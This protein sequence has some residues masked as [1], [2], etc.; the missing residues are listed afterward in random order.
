MGRTTMKSKAIFVALLALA[1]G[2]QA[3]PVI[4]SEAAQ[5]AK[6]W[7][8]SGLVV[9]AT[10]E[11]VTSHATAQGAGF[12]AV[13]LS[14]GGTVFLSGD[15]TRR[16]VIAL[17]PAGAETIDPKSPLWAL[18]SRDQDVQAAVVSANAAGGAGTSASADKS[19]AEREW[20]ELLAE[21]ADRGTVV[22]PAKAV[23]A[24]T[25]HVSSLSDVRV[26]P[27]VK[28]KWAQSTAY[29]KRCYNYYTPQ[30]S[31]KSYAVCGCVATAMSQLMRY[32]RYPTG[33]VT[34]VTRTC[35][36]EPSTKSKAVATKELTTQ[37]GVYDWS[38]MP[39]VPEDGVTDEQCQAIG[40]L[41]SDAGISVCMNYDTLKAG[42][43]GAFMFNVVRALKE[44]FGYASA[45]YYRAES[46]VTKSSGVVRNAMLS[47]FDAGYPVLMGVSGD[48]GHAIVGDGY[49]YKGDTLYVH[50]NMGWAGQDNVWYNL[51]DIDCA[52]SGYH[53]TTFEDV[54][55]NVFPKTGGTA[56][57]SG[58]V[59]DDEGTGVES[60]R[61]EICRSGETDPVVVDLTTNGVYGARLAPGTYDVTAFTAGGK[62]S[63][64]QKGVLVKAPTV[65]TTS[66]TGVIYGS[67]T[68]TY[69][70]VPIATAVGN[71]QNSK[72]IV[73]YQPTVQ[74]GTTQYATLDKALAAAAAVYEADPDKKPVTIE[75]IDA[76][77]LEKPFT[78][79]FPCVLTSADP[80]TL[81]VTRAAGAVL[82]VAAGGKVEVVN[83]TV[84]GAASEKVFNV[85]TGGSVTIGA[86]VNLG[87]S[88]TVP[89]IVTAQADGF[90]FAGAP[91]V[92]FAVDC[93]AARG[94]DAVFGYAT[95]DFATAAAWAPKFVNLNDPNGEIAGVAEDGGSAP[96][97]LKWDV[98][99][100]PLE[101][102]VAY[103][104]L[105][106]TVKT[107]CFRR[108]DRLFELF[109][110][111]D[112]PGEVTI[113]ADC[114]MTR[115]V[116]VTHDLTIRSENGAVVSGPSSSSSGG[117][118]VPSGVTLVVDGLSFDGLSCNSLFVVNGGVL[119]LKGDMAI[120]NF[121][122]TGSPTAAA[123]CA[124]NGARVVVGSD[125]GR[126]VFES[127]VNDASD[128]STGGAMYAY[129]SDANRETEI[130]LAGDV[131]ITGCR[132][133]GAGGGIY[134]GKAAALSLSG[135]LT[136]KDNV[137]G[138]G[139]STASDVYCTSKA[140]GA[141]VVG[142]VKTGSCV[143]IR[144]Q[145]GSNVGAAFAAVDGLTEAEVADSAAAFF[146]DGKDGLVAAP[147]DDD[148]SLVWTEKP[149]GIKPVSPDVAHVH[150]TGASGSDDYYASIEDALAVLA[151]ADGTIEIMRDTTI[152]SN[153]VI[154]ANVTL[155]GDENGPYVITRAGPYEFQV[156]DGATLT[157]ENL[158]FS[159]EGAAEHLFYVDGGEFVL[160]DGATIEKVNGDATHNGGAVRIIA[161]G[162]FV[163]KKGSRIADCKNPYV[164]DYLLNG[165]GGA[166]LA[167]RDSFV[168]LEGGVIESCEADLG[169]GIFI[170]NQSTV[171][172]GGD[173]TV[174]ANGDAS[175]APGN[176]YVPI[177]SDLLLIAPL[178]TGAIGVTQDEAA[179]P[180]VFGHVSDEFTGTDAQLADSAHRFGN[181]RNGDVGI[182]VRNGSE[183]LLVW[184]DGLDANGNYVADGKTYV[185]VSGGETLTAEM[186]N[187]V[188]PTRVYT[189]SE[190][191]G[192]EPGHGF[193]ITGDVATDAGSYTATL[194]PKS[195]FVWA[196][197]GTT[198]E[199]TLEWSIAKADYD[200]SRVTFEDFTCPYD[201]KAKTLVIGGKLPA[202]VTVAYYDE[203]GNVGGNVQTNAG[204]YK[205]TAKFTGEDTKNY[206][207]IG[208][209]TKTLT[210]TKIAYD[211][212][213]ITFEDAEYVFDGTEKKIEISG[214]LPTGVT[215][216][217]YD[218]GGNVGGNVQ[219]AV[220]IYQ[221]TARFSGDT[222]NH[223][224]I[225]DVLT[226][227]LT[228]KQDSPGPGPTPIPVPVVDFAFTDISRQADGSWL[229]TIFPVKQYCK[230]TLQT[231]TDLKNWTPVGGPVEAP[232]DGELAF[233]PVPGGEAKRFWQA[234]GEDGE[235]PAE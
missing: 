140:A 229:L 100:V 130:V 67:W 39:L 203:G 133:R 66:Y 215:V 26:G 75:V 64:S 193:V 208:D 37:G 173:A 111:A 137:S 2:A 88:A 227:T 190:L 43:S 175:G 18:L 38:K 113:L 104:V 80:E 6:A 164:S 33:S 136:V 31:D 204:V 161:K 117:F 68:E 126:V 84:A 50:L 15:T 138:S 86:G 62:M 160:G 1:F 53:F 157:V 11:R 167:D 170:G 177:Y 184:S 10:A 230:Y 174:T 221:I 196:D 69:K 30:L 169:A 106:G 97:A 73:L 153:L 107:N 216:A 47:N 146:C 194:K 145:A 70:N 34:P 178:T 60:A 71:N 134:L 217:Y 124:T 195:G 72:A 44:V 93:T 218:E 189:G 156:E 150:V 92:P 198:E 13:R 191:K 103:S 149:S 214:K 211:L 41:T 24:A 23:A 112:S 45:C 142:L 83:L 162:R 234:V 118:D 200:M 143:G 186:P 4:E 27:L 108:L 19:T 139:G 46:D 163:M 48:G 187:V 5:A 222:V 120:R 17:V 122:G 225:A 78:V 90:V 144:Q 127:C 25:T 147:S 109:E 228:I 125:A 232:S 206:N 213:G 220:G 171:E 226:A 132:C 185:P 158:T 20:A 36:V 116:A 98:V 151:G 141:R 192:I 152:V 59:V 3:R 179:D 233:P 21:G 168:R 85:L 99:E 94:L 89:A 63:E 77:T 14:G 56:T 180:V 212:S 123:I 55:F 91:A 183:T 52:K 95:C 219:T 205:V 197:S 105:D 9:E 166:V 28:S 61:V 129:A 176:V 121:T 224:P 40:K 231:S 74:I 114:S 58:R 87:V 110:K 101:E 65:T 159:G 223:E 165:R 7:A 42:G 35:Y 32:H 181:D 82:T 12:Y 235:K 135:L 115:R 49:G 172:V 22:R 207:L 188:T 202:G 199:R 76:T 81:E 51:P 57:L 182:A 201:G 79:G 148:T 29:G 16:P 96:Y 209:K 128:Q 54:V 102:A 210:I 155:K 131:S 8:K 119:E 154:A